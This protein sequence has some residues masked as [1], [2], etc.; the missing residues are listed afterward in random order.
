MEYHVNPITGC[1]EWLLHLDK[2]GY[3]HKWTGGKLKNGGG[4]KPAYRVYYEKFKGPVPDGKQLDH[5]CR[6]PRCVNPE[7]LEPVT[8]AENVRRGNAAK[9][10]WTD[11]QLIRQ[12]YASGANQMILAERFNI[13]QSMVSRIIN[14]NRWV[15]Q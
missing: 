1:W 6:N 7:H 9:L 3:G 13:S 12:L 4:P 8:G 15:A 2:N 11:I 10:S 5:L 14:K